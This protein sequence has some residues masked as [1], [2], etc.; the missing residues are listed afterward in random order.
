VVTEQAVEKLTGL[1]AIA[2]CCRI[3]GALFYLQPDDPVV[4][5]ILAFLDEGTL[6]QTWPFGSEEELTRV[7]RDMRRAKLADGGIKAMVEE[8]QYL[9]TGPDHLEAPPWGS[10]YRDEEGLLFGET[11]LEVRDF[12]ASEGFV[13]NTVHNEPD[14]HIG[15]LFWAAAWFAEKQQPSALR[16]LLEDH[17]LPWSDEY[18]KR[19]VA[20][21][22][23]PFYKNL[24]I[25]A[26]LTLL[27][28]Q[29][30]N[31][32]LKVGLPLA[33]WKSH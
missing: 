19:F 11:T 27:E 13:L 17:I 5:P 9:F 8:Y 22:N 28:M 2:V 20:A 12:L 25:L 16:K 14:D 21:A 6:P 30:V 1:S 18:L 32:G 7:G 31:G 10:V 23:N 24:G 29:A 3:L 4:Q 15:L 33:I 26:R